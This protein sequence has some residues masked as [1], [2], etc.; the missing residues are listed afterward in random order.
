MWGAKSDKDCHTAVGRPFSLFTEDRI[1]A[2]MSKM[3]DL[4]RARMQVYS[5]S[6]TKY[7]YMHDLTDK[8]VCAL[9]MNACRILGWPISDF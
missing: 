5:D 6:D 2:Y 1:L 8:F 4:A 7:F 3:A 9:C